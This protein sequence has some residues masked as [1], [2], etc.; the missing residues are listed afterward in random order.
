MPVKAPT[1]YRRLPGD[2]SLNETIYIFEYTQ[3]QGAI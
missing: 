3:R 2:T 1:L